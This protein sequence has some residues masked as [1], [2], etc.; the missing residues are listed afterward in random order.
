MWKPLVNVLEKKMVEIKKSICSYDCPSSCGFL[1]EVEDGKIVS[2]RNDPEHP[3]SRNGICRKT[4]HYEKSIYSEKRILTPLRRCGEKGSGEFCP[5]TWPEAIREITDRWK[6]LIHDFGPE[7]IWPWSYSGVMSDI[8]RGCGDAFFNRMGAAGQVRTLCSPAKGAAYKAVCGRTGC[9]DPRELNDSDYYIV[10]GSNMAAT[11]LQALADLNNPKNRNKKKILIDTY[12]N[13]SAKYFDQVICIRAG[14]DGALALAMMQVLNE[15]ELSDETFLADYTE[16]YETFRAGLSRYT[17]EWAEKETGVPA[18]VIRKLAR[19]YASFRAPAILL[20]SGNSRYENG[21]MTVRLI[22]ILSLFSGAWQYPGGGLCGCTPVDRDYVD[23]NL[24]KRPDFR[25]K[26]VRTLNINQ[27]ARTLALTG[28]EAVR[29]LYVYGGN[30]AN[31]VSNQDGIIEGLKRDD[32]FTVVHERF[33]TET[34]LYAD[35]ILPATFSVEQYDIYRA[36]GYCT[37]GTA[38]PVIKAPGECKSNWDTF[39]LLAE[40]M[41]YEE[42]Y[43]RRSEEEMFTFILDHPTPAVEALSEEKKRVLREGGCVAMPCSDHLKIGTPSGKFRIINEELADPVPAYKPPCREE[44]QR[45]PY[46][47]RL[48]ASPSVYTLN[49]QFRDRT[50]LMEARGGQKLIMHILDASDRQIEDGDTVLAFNDQS[51]VVFTAVLTDHIARGNVICEGVYRRDQ[52]VGD[53]A[54]N[55]LTSERLSDMGE[56]TTMNGN[57]VEVKRWISDTFFDKSALLSS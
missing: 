28:D 55:S 32:L 43:F 46:P 40:A 11:R 57:R 12:A 41:G 3:V 31:T 23:M 36:Y 20:G 7:T 25:Q 35:I 4:R 19:E 27:T 2:V 52:C 53:R 49:S 8:Q 22:V 44:M 29:A 39:C 15:E 14:T 9:L 50:D 42:E 47:L 16:G 18:D 10:W 34:A 51:E 45:D 30:P 37:L 13:P 33:M 54:F 21:G 24:I 5:I 26:E 48:V 6:A 17:P 38:R 56:G 1:M